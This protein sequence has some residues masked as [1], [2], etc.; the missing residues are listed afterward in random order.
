MSDLLD[1]WEREFIPE[2][3]HKFQ[4]SLTDFINSLELEEYK[5]IIIES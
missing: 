5:Q 4:A 3:L 1:I 2:A